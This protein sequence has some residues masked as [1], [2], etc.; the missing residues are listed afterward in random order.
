MNTI[1]NLLAAAALAAVSAASSAAGLPDT[2]PIDLHATPPASE[3]TAAEVRAQANAANTGTRFV[4]QG[5]VLVRNP[6]YVQTVTP[7]SRAD[8]RAEG[9]AAL[10][11]QPDPR[12]QG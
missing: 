12:A 7:R 4:E 11:V 8:V 2:A 9:R 5:D 10:R 1:R 3:P 6:N